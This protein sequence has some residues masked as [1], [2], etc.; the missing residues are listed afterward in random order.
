[1][2]KGFTLMELLGIIVILAII[3]IITT[4][5]ILNVIQTS[6]EKAFIDTGYSIVSAAK[7]YQALSMGKNK[8]LELTVNYETKENVDALKLKGNLPDS[9]MFHIDE[10]GNSELALWSK[11]A[12]VCITKN[13]DSK[14]IN[15]NKTL[16]KETC[17]L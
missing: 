17:K 6:R 10:N 13:K 14:K 5:V 11:S 2:N 3:A 9:G 16:T 7:N 12:N 4:P 1:M 15:I 8:Q